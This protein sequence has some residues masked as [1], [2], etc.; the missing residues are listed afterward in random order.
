M[1]KSPELTMDDC[2]AHDNPNSWLILIAFGIS[3]LI[4]GS[5]AYLVWSPAVKKEDNP[6]VHKIDISAFDED[7]KKIYELVSAKEG[8]AYQSDLIKE[9][10]ISKV[11]M[12]RILDRLEGKGIIERKRRG[13]TNV[14][15]LK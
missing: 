3:F 10:N 1:E 4:I 6:K 5:G 14:V 13:M 2:P 8:S 15:V 12:S 7:E 11:R 9:L